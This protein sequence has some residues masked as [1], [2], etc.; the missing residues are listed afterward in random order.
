MDKNAENIELTSEKPPNRI[1]FRMM[2]FM[3]KT[4]D[5][6][7]PPK[8]KIQNIGLKPGFTVL[9]YGCGPGSFIVPV[10]EIVG[11]TGKIY[12]ADIHSL[13]ITKIKKM[14]L[15]KKLNIETILIDKKKNDTGL[16]NNS[17]DAIFCFDMLHFIKDSDNLMD[18]FHRVLKENSVLYVD[19][20]HLKEEEIISKVS[21]HN[22]FKLT[23]KV[24]NIYNFIK[25][26]N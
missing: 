18:E 24:E 17:I 21:S 8:Q 15:K 16:E 1:H 12:A 2:S 10:A 14:A 9:D 6:F 22:L 25:I 23:N 3:L 11:D 26:H 19:C 4:R 7:Q 20:H 13:A 5:I